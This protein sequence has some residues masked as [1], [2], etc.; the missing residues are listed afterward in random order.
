MAR[1]ITQ[2]IGSDNGLSKYK[3]PKVEI[4]KNVKKKICFITARLYQ[5]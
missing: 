4:T 3:K 5:T 1:V 2:R